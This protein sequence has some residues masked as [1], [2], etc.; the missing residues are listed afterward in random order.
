MLVTIVVVPNADNTDMDRDRMG[1][2]EDLPDEVAVQML[3]AGTAR[4]PS[5]D[6][7]DTYD[8]DQE[9]GASP[10]SD[11]DSGSD[12]SVTG[13]QASAQPV[14]QVDTR[15]P[16]TR[17]RRRSAAKQ[18]QPEPLAVNP[19]ALPAGTPDTAG[20]AEAAPAPA[21]TA[22]TKPDDQSGAADTTT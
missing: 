13:D 21:D 19:A 4:E 16:T 5:D 8:R 18:T 11:S 2:V 3:Q 6:E 20:S 9:D 10:G 12:T 14:D 17:S 22:A 15:P 7:L 1:R